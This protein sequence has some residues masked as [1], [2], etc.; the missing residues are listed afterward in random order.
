MGEMP[1][2][3]RLQEVDDDWREEV[4]VTLAK[5]QWTRIRL[6]AEAECDPSTITD[7]LRRGPPTRST[8]AAVISAKLGIPLPSARD[9]EADELYRKMLRLKR[10]SRPAFDGVSRMVDGFLKEK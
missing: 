6:A 10:T 3:R 4:D 7:L 1:K 2:G 9:P 5:K 8:Y